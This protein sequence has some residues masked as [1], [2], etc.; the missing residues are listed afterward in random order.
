MRCMICPKD[1][2]LLTSC[3]EPARPLQRSPGPPGPKCLTPKSLKKVSG[4]VW[5]VSGRCLESVFGVFRDFLETFW[6]PGPGD[7]FETFWAFRARRAQETSVRGGLVPK[8][9]VQMKRL[10]LE[11]Q[12]RQSTGTQAQGTL[13]PSPFSS[14]M[15]S[16]PS[17]CSHQHSEELHT[18]LGCVLAQA[19]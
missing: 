6:V 1:S 19:S 15:K 10:Q 9:L 13:R 11:G 2:D 3:W 7:I 14:A 5:Q 17:P 8:H 16:C 4:T 18:T 12:L